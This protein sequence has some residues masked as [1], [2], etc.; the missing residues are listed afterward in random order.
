MKD[1]LLISPNKGYAAVPLL[2]GLEGLSYQIRL[3]IQSSAQQEG[4]Y[5]GFP[6]GDRMVGFNLD[7]W[8]FSGH[9]TGLSAVKG[10]ATDALPGALH[11]RQVQD[12]KPHDLELIVQLIGSEARIS[13]RLDGRSLYEWK[14]PMLDL[15]ESAGWRT[16]PGQ[17][18]IGTC[19]ANWRV[20]EVK[21]RRLK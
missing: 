16:Q 4:L 2:R 1:G 6:V 5:L 12:F 7:G 18:A 13:T 14:G 3:K 8:P 11:G 17:F 10:R 9:Y 20:L 15:T 19:S 21:A